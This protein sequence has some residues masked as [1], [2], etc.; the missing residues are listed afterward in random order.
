MALPTHEDVGVFPFLTL[1]KEL[2]DLIHEDLLT[3]RLPS[4]ST[5]KKWH[6]G[7]AHTSILCTC[8]QIRDEASR[9]LY[10][11][12]LLILFNKEFMDCD[13][14]WVRVGE[15]PEIRTLDEWALEMN[16]DD[17]WRSRAEVPA[18]YYK[19]DSFRI[20]LGMDCWDETATDQKIVQEAALNAIVHLNSFTYTILLKHPSLRKIHFVLDPV[21]TNLNIR[22]S[23]KFMQKYELSC[24]DTLGRLQGLE[25]VTLEGIRF[26]DP[27]Y[28]ASIESQMLEPLPQSWNALSQYSPMG[29]QP[30]SL[31][32]GEGADYPQVL[33]PLSTPQAQRPL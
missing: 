18:Y 25:K 26:Q 21:P 13:V 10:S 30:L 15:Y 16:K 31:I 3:L 20:H 4:H 19:C 8:R 2:R 11:N 1:P 12:Q 24:L 14:E 5:R 9:V 32:S 28:V 17:S 22:F 6:H 7:T 29:I 27:A 23:D 33:L